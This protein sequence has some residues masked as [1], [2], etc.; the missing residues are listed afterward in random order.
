M[1]QL[2][3]WGI[4]LSA[5]IKALR[6]FLLV[7]VLSTVFLVGIGEYFFYKTEL[8]NVLQ[9]EKLSLK[10]E[11]IKFLNQNP[12]IMKA[13]TFKELKIPKNL[14]LRLYFNEKLV[15][16]NSPLEDIT[17][18]HYEVKR[19]GKVKIIAT[20]KFPKE[21]VNKI[22]LK[23]MVFN[24]FFLI[25]LMVVAYFLG[26]IFL[27]P[28][29][30]VINNLEGFIR[31]ATHEM[32][33]PI[34]VILTNIE[35]LDDDSKPI[36][37][38]KSSAIRLNKIFDD[39]KYIRL[40]HKRPKHL[41]DINLLEFIKKRIEMFEILAANKNLKFSLNLENKII[42][43]DEEDLS[44]IVD[45]LISNAIKYAPPNSTIEII[46]KDNKFCTIN[47]GEI[48]DIQKVKQKFV[49]ESSSEGGFGLGLYI[50]DMVAK[51]YGLNFEIKN[52]D[53]KVYCCVEFKERL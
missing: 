41:K 2:K 17:V 37:R 31:D 35:L 39:L 22:I 40:H 12:Y 33:T 8:N 32:N 18:T 44:R 36:R 6:R 11:V 19:W 27:M 30:E 3:T 53:A 28:M 29:K 48:K 50:V 46:L 7:Y 45:N 4:N 47:E 23:L 26:R 24:L 21:K 9:K 42:E 52:K 15:Y 20:E 13:I 49:R 1:L 34:S 51:E 5:E 25:F 38:I 14:K 43:F 10:T 16:A